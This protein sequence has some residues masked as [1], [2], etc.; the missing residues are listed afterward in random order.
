MIMIEYFIEPSWQK[1]F[2]VN[3]IYI[4]LL[5]ILGANISVLES[6]I[7]YILMKTM[8]RY[9]KNSD[10]TVIAT[11]HQPLGEIF[12]K[13]DNILLLVKGQ[14]IRLILYVLWQNLL[15]KCYHPLTNVLRNSPEL[16]YKCIC[17]WT[18]LKWLCCWKKKKLNLFWFS[19]IQM[20]YVWLLLRLKTQQYYGLW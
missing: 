12:H 15:V 13:F 1:L 14:V 9:T 19:L 4:S 6:V 20:S 3:Y 16:K 18:W 7:A 5:Y 17:I 10:K 8:K 11:I 2:W